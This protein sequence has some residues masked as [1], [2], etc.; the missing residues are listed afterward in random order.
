MVVAINFN[1]IA[2]FNHEDFSFESTL[3]CLYISHLQNAKNS[4]L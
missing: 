4:E 1:S 3:F 2:K